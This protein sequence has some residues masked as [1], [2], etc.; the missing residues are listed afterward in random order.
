MAALGREN[1][2]LKAYA[3]SSRVYKCYVI[4]TD[5]WI[6]DSLEIISKFLEVK[7]FLEPLNGGKAF[8]SIYGII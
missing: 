2:S 8:N 1:I 7:R 4:N 5:N 3:W 6:T